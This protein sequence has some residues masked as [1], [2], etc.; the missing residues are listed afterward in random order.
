MARIRQLVVRP[1]SCIR[2]ERFIIFSRRRDL[3]DKLKTG[4]IRGKR[5]G[6]NLLLSLV[7]VG[8]KGNKCIGVDNVFFHR[9]FP[10]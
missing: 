4:Y 10:I 6:D 8:D 1:L 2:V 5:G 9:Y 7:S 3:T